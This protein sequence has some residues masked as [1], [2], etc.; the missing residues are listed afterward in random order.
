MASL[1]SKSIKVA[2]PRD[3]WGIVRYLGE[4]T[5][6]N[7]RY[8]FL[9]LWTNHR[10]RGTQ[11]VA[12]RLDVADYDNLEEFTQTLCSDTSFIPK[13]F[14]PPHSF[15]L[16]ENGVASSVENVAANPGRRMRAV[17]FDEEGFF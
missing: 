16:I 4:F 9:L 2:S 3:E 7:E 10:I 5:A 1:D 13:S 11:V 17:K 6:E 14:D 12:V 8:K 15:T